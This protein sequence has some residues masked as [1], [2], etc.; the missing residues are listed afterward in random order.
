VRLWTVL[1]VVAA[2][3]LYAV[4]LSDAVYEAT[5]PYWLSWH[6]LLRKSYSVAAFAVVGYLLRRALTER[7]RREI[8]WSTVLGVAAYSAAIEVGQAFAGSREGLL[9]NTVDT[10][11]GAL[12]GALACAGLILRRLLRRVPTREWPQR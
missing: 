5:S 12:G 3:A 1:A 2:A 10:A 9:W 8:L 6:V 11:C 4:A 7:G